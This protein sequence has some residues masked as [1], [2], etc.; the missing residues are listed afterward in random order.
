MKEADYQ[1]WKGNLTVYGLDL[2]SLKAIREFIDYYHSV[3][4]S[5]DIL[6][7]NAAQ[8]IKYTEE[9][10]LPMIE[11][12]Q[13][14]LTTFSSNRLLGNLHS[15]TKAVDIHELSNNHELDLN[16]FGQPVD[17][18]EKNSW[19]STLEEIDMAE[20][21]EV[22][23]INQIAPYYLIKEL[24]GLMRVSR[25]AKQFI[26]NVTS[27]EGQFS[28]EN[29]TIFH[30]HTNMTKASLN[31]LTRTSAEEYQK[32]GIYMNAVDVGWVSTG[33]REALRQK[34]FNEGYIPPLDP[35][36]G[37]SRIM[38]PIINGIENEDETAGKLWKNYKIVDW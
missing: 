21:L 22:N 33:A 12:E 11:R 37:A 20:L 24:A 6:I 34:Q 18:R 26:I 17:T 3:N 15:P 8:T 38:V 4:D 36:D 28:Y 19:N 25:F 29:K 32:Y 27:S 30:P 14:F 16:R 35:V 5:L 23:L 13:K 10:Y 7:N 31:M 9:Y 2:R 1:V